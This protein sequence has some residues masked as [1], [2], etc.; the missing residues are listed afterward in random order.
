[1]RTRTRCA[2]GYAHAQIS[3]DHAS[4]KGQIVGV[5]YALTNQ[6]A[7]YRVVEN[8]IIVTSDDLK[9]RGALIGVAQPTDL[10]SP[11]SMLIQNIIAKYNYR[12]RRLSE[13]IAV[14]NY[15]G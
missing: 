8:C 10:W 2:S 5:F 15:M 11:Y 1:M 9:L 4:N 3:Y 13:K 14:D 12:E 6:I 7:H